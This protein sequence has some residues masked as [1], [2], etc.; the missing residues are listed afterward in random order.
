MAAVPALLQLPGAL[1]AQGYEAVQL[2][3]VDVLADV[4]GGFKWV[5]DVKRGHLGLVLLSTLDESVGW[6]V[7]GGGSSADIS[8]TL[9]SS[10]SHKVIK[11]ELFNCGLTMERIEL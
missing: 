1:L 7:G 6:G 10:S 5:L 2:R 4:E 3:G 11:C 9:N 8:K